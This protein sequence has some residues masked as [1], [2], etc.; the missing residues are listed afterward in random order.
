MVSLLADGKDFNRPLDILNIELGTAF[1][2][3]GEEVLPDLPF[4][5]ST[6]AV[7][8]CCSWCS[9]SP[10]GRTLNQLWAVEARVAG[11]RLKIY[12]G[13]TFKNELDIKEKVQ[14]KRKTYL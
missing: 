6:S 8:C 5:N 9:L 11:L 2:A 13:R 7:I 14:L 10:F 3:E 12:M 4:S 1:G